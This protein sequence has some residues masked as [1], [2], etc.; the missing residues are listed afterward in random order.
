MTCP[1]TPAYLAHA[2]TLGLHVSHV[3]L[4]CASGDG[5]SKADRGRGLHAEEPFFLGGG[6]GGNESKRLPEGLHVSTCQVTSQV[7]KTSL[8]VATTHDFAVS[9]R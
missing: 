7:E 6:C 8:N 1:G 2:T 9:C 3:L 4:P 5:G